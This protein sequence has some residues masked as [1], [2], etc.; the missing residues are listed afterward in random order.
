MDWSKRIRPTVLFI[1]AVLA[2]ICFTAM[3]LKIGNIAEMSLVAI[4]GALTQI[5]ES[6][7]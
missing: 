6:E 4:A 3:G 2:G 5:F 1:V 7:K